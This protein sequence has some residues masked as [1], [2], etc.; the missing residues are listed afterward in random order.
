M[1]STAA[2]QRTALVDALRAV[3]PDAPTLC[4]GWQARDLAEHLVIRDHMPYAVVTSE[5]PFLG[6]RVRRRVGECEAKSYPEL[7]EL[8]ASGAPKCSPT[9]CA[10]LDHLLNTA[11]F[12]IHTEDV[13]RA[14]PGW[15]PDQARQASPAL[16]RTLWRQA[17]RTF[18][19]MAARQHRWR[20]TYISPGVGA[21]THGRGSDELRLVHGSPEELVLWASGREDSAQVEFANPMRAFISDVDH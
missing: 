14:Q 17:S 11:E 21:V 3:E 8:I 19:V 2:T 6:P 9:R 5:L 13:L 16:R 4:E 1:T 12:Y 18:F 15:S 7:L 10:P 20:L